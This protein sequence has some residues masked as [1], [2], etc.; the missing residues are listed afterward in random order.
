MAKIKGWRKKRF[1][2]GSIMYQ[3][4]TPPIKTEIIIAKLIRSG[5]WNVDPNP[6]RFKEKSFKKKS[7]ALKFAKN[8]M[9]SHPKG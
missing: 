5:R 7:Q 9:K 2:D 6:Q 3:N 8:W 1:K 4:Q